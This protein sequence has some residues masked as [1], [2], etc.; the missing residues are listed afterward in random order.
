MG[1]AADTGHRAAIDYGAHE[2]L[3]NLSRKRIE[4]DFPPIDAEGCDPPLARRR[5]HHVPCMGEAFRPLPPAQ[6][7]RTLTRHTDR[8]R[9]RRHDTGHVKLRQKPAL[10][11][12]GPPV[13]SGARHG[14]EA[15]RT[16]PPLVGGARVQALRHGAEPKLET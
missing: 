14:D 2:A 5:Q 9:R 13:A 8:P 7:I 12:P 1:F 3:G 11:R 10:P 6:T 16:T 4:C 15:R